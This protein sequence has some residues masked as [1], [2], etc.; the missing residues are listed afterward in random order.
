MRRTRSGLIRFGDQPALQRFGR[1]NASSM[2][3]NHID[4]RA[5]SA[6]AI[7]APEN[8]REAYET[9]VTSLRHCAGEVVWRFDAG[10]SWRRHCQQAASNDA[11]CT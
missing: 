6:P 10:A 8:R 3:F 7:E 4:K 2:G 9:P 5:G 11:W 1:G